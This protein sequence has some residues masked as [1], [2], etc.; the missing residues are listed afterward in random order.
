MKT[1]FFLIFLFSILCVSCNWTTQQVATSTD[2]MAY[3]SEKNRVYWEL[4]NSTIYATHKNDI[5]FYLQNTNWFKVWNNELRRQYIE[6][7]INLY[8]NK[9]GE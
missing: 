2:T 4:N 5:E 9:K 1:R 7:S 8:L 6:E 3:L